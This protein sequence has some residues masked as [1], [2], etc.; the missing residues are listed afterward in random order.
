M[1]ACAL[2]L[3]V[4]AIVALLVLTVLEHFLPLP[5]SLVTLVRCLVGVLLLLWFLSCLGV[6]PA[7]PVRW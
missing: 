1:L 7:L 5:P 2:W 4:W 3:V 6:L